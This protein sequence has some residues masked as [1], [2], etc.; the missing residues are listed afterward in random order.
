MA[1]S[2]TT[3]N[4]WQKLLQPGLGG[5]WNYAGLTPHRVYQAIKSGDWNLPSDVSEDAF[6]SDIISD[7]DNS[8]LDFSNISQSEL[9]DILNKY[10]EEDDGFFS[11]THTFDRDRFISDYNSILAANANMP[12]APDAARLWQEAQ[13]RANADAQGDLDTL[14]QLYNDEMRSLASGYGTARSDILS[15]QYRQNAQL[16]DTMTSQLDR[17]NR[18]ALEAGASAGIRLAGNVN[19]LLSTQNK[20]SQ[21]SLETAN[22]LSQMMISQRNAEASARGNYFDKQ[23]SVKD[24]AFGKA[25]DYYDREYGV[26]QDSYGKQMQDWDNANYGNPLWDTKLGKSKYNKTGV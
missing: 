17:Q 3:K 19:T 26:A 9:E 16:M 11:T 13:D 24:A 7:L 15:N 2:Y 5:V 20:Q 14:R 12:E 10:W 6:T 8:G 22:Q 25:Q 21:T 23:R 1:Y 18:N 4:W